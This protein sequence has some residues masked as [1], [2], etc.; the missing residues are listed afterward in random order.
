MTFHG[1]GTLELPSLTNGDGSNFQVTSGTFSLPALTSYAAG[2]VGGPVT[3]QAQGAGSVLAIPNLA[4]LTGNTYYN[5]FWGDRYSLWINALS[6][7]RVDLGGLTDIPSGG[8]QFVADGADSV[9]DVSA[10]TSFINT[11]ASGI[12]VQNEG[13]VLAPNL[14]TLNSVW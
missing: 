3:F 11:N 4:R 12:E 10:L 9:I 14:A 8:T 2:N 1:T 13:T 6:R 7:G 5:S